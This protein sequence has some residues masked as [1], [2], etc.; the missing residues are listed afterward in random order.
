MIH[1]KTQDQIET[2]S[3]RNGGNRLIDKR[4]RDTDIGRDTAQFSVY[5]RTYVLNCVS[6][7]WVICNCGR[8]RLG[9]L[10][11]VLIN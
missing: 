11:V 1:L 2:R 8:G 9:I 10:P 4:H 6:G 7:N 3:K 5:V